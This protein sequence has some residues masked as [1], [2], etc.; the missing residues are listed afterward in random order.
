MSSHSLEQV[1]PC[2]ESAFQPCTNGPQFTM[3][4]LTIFALYNLQK[5]TI[6][7]PLLSV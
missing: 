3:V 2:S 5:H 7:L 4:W 1:Y 6:I